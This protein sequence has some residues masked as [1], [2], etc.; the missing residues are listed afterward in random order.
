MGKNSK[1][2]VSYLTW[3]IRFFWEPNLVCAPHIW[4]TC[5]CE[6]SETSI[7]VTKALAAKVYLLLLPGIDMSWQ[8]TSLLFMSLFAD[9]NMLSGSRAPRKNNKKYS[10]IFQSETNASRLILGHFEYFLRSPPNSEK[11]Q[12]HFIDNKA[13]IGT[14]APVYLFATGPA[15]TTK[16]LGQGGFLPEKLN[17]NTQFHQTPSERILRNRPNPIYHQN[18]KIIWTYTIES[19]EVQVNQ[20][21]HF[22]RIGNQLHGSS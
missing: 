16:S 2:K 21:L 10:S 1:S 13:A 7:N 15:R 6:G 11:V 9:C 12:R 8:L 17:K 3:I 19:Q 14:R 22:G 5:F 4:P 18:N 20:T